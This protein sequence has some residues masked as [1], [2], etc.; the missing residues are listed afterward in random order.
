MLLVIAACVAVL[1]VSNIWLL[2][3]VEALRAR[4][5]ACRD[6]VSLLDGRLCRL[7]AEM[8]ERGGPPH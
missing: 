4:V 7:M 5:N 6:E 3:E 2:K 8:E 1:L